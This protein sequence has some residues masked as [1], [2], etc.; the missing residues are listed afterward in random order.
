VERRGHV[1]QHRTSANWHQEEPVNGAKPFAIAKQEVW[2]AYLQVKAN[3]GAAGVDA[4]SIEAFERDVK[5][6]LYRLWNR[7]ASGSYFPPPVRE[8][9]IP[10]R[11]GG[12]RKLGVPTVADRIAQTVVKNY[13]EPKVEPSF[14]GDSYGYR[15]GKSAVDAVGRARERCWQYDWVVDLDIRAFFDSLDHELAMRAVRKYT[16]C[17]WVLLYVERW[18]KAPVQHE[19]GTLTARQSGTPQG[20]VVSPLLA[21]IFL[22]LAFDTWVERAFPQVAFERYADDILV[23][24]RTHEG[25]EK[26]RQAVQ[27]RLAR[28]KLEVHPGKTKVVY[29]QDSNRRGSHPVSSFDFLSFTFR[30]RRVRNR[31]GEYFVSF[32]PAIS[33]QAAKRIRQEMHRS[34]RLPRRTDKDLSDLAHMFNPAIRGWIGYFG[35]YQKSALYPVFRHL[36]LTLTTWAMRKYRRLKGHRR[37]AAYWLGRIACRQPRLFA[38]WQLLGVRPTAG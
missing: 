17:R 25:A 34:W 21:N 5:G 30:P 36:N 19:D 38:H 18:L 23:H 28:C 2:K 9:V 7:M 13:L 37:R 26:V 24:C 8:V 29:C 10:K 4:E 1:N 35:S 31:R 33:R 32:S 12:A 14:H 15:P 6:N 22:H 11:D 3:G 20:G 27:E 16:E